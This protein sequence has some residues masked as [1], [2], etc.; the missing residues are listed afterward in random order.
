MFFSYSCAHPILCIDEMISWK[1]H[2][3]AAHRCFSLVTSLMKIKKG[4][5][6][7][8][9][10]KC[11]ARLHALCFITWSWSDKFMEPALMLASSPAI[12]HHFWAAPSLENVLCSRQPVCPHLLSPFVCVVLGFHHKCHI[13][14]YYLQMHATFGIGNLFPPER[15]IWLQLGS[16]E[17]CLLLLSLFAL[18]D[19]WASP[20]RL[21]GA[22]SWVLL[23]ECL[24]HGWMD[25]WLN[26]GCLIGCLPPG[27]CITAGGKNH[28]TY[29]N[30]PVV[31]S[32]FTR[33]VTLLL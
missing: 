11:C 18:V 31:S 12:G 23:S 32:L 20:T 5:S 33:N 14:I 28:L 3:Q 17:I 1:F 9:S 30:G 19:M 7:R 22:T 15:L 16:S 13:K 4:G 27:K 6:G 10:V 21:K 8:G 29:V 2:L 25:V 24:W 26:Q